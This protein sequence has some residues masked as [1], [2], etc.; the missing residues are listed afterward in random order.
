MTKARF[1]HICPDRECSYTGP[2]THG[3]GPSAEKTVVKPIPG[4]DFHHPEINKTCYEFEVPPEGVGRFFEQAG[5]EALYRCHG[6]HPN[7]PACTCEQG[8]TSG[9]EPVMV[10]N[11]DCPV[12]GTKVREEL[13]A[14]FP[15]VDSDR[16][17]FGMPG[18]GVGAV[19]F[20][21][22]ENRDRPTQAERV[23][24]IIADALELFVAKNKGY[25]EPT[26]EDLGSRGQYADMHRKWKRLKATLWE[27]E[28]WPETGESLEEVLMD[29]IGHLG[30][31]IDFLREGK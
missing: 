18:L 29:F 30:L 9:D 5:T 21:P 4:T 10:L 13:A 27:G 1:I 6:E 7:Q 17:E 2:H 3:S 19:M 20:I 16:G 12:H 8:T 14:K 22:P 23:C 15:S 25:G 24:L 11:P 31:T 28:P 26:G